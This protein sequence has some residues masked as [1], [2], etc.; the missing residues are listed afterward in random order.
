MKNLIKPPKAVLIVKLY[1]YSQ[2]E[3]EISFSKGLILIIAT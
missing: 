2:T 1:S 3:H